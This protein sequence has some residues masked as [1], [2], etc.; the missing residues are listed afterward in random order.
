M[1]F[2]VIDINTHFG[3]LPYRD[4]DVS[5][6][7]LLN[8]MRKYGIS[9]ALTYSLKGVSYDAVEGN[10]ETYAIIQAHPELV[11]VATVDPRRHIGV[12]DEIEKRR[13]QGFVALRI[14]PEAQCWRINSAM[15][16][17]ILRTLESL[18]MPLIVSGAGS[19]TPT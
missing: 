18:Q 16:R 12:I 10:D 14:F 13:G 11:P 15:L 3:F 9:T 4:T 5:L 6:N 1:N 2:S 19:G 7:T 8:S 17:P